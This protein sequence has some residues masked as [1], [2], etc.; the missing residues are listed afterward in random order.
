MRGEINGHQSQLVHDS[1]GE[2]SAQDRIRSLAIMCFMPGAPF[3][4]D[5]VWEQYEWGETVM[6]GEQVE[7]IVPLP[8]P[9]AQQR[10]GAED[11]RSECS[12]RFRHA[13]SVPVRRMHHARMWCAEGNVQVGMRGCD[14]P[15]PVGQLSRIVHDVPLGCAE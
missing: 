4:L 2:I 5:I 8:A 9:V 13:E 15:V 7:D 6:S 14:K 12:R 1:F 3:R 10:P 11:P